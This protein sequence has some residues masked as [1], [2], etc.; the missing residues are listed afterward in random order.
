MIF[1][2]LIYIFTGIGIV[3]GSIGAMFLVMFGICI[4]Y[5]LI[6]DE[7]NRL[8]SDISWKKWKRADEQ[9]A[10]SH[11]EKLASKYPDLEITYKKKKL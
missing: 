7:W 6:G 4:L 3:V 5:E 2:D 8:R 9:F 10:V 11:L 1:A